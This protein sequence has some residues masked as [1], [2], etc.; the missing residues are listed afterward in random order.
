[1]NDFTLW[2]KISSVSAVV[3]AIFMAVVPE[4]KLKSAYKVISTFIVI[5]SLFSAVFS[6]ELTDVDLFT[7]DMKE[8]V[9]LSEKTDEMLIKEGER[10]LDG[11]LN[12]KLLEKG[13]DLRCESELVFYEERLKPEKI[14]VYGSLSSEE[15]EQ[16]MEII[17]DTLKEESEVIFAKEDNEE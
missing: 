5:F 15:K 11:I 8:S 13:F 6:L 2:L 16:V 17:H 9:S 7:G 1:M 14:R 4:N 12:E 3:S 10:L